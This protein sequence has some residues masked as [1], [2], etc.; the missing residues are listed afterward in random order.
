ML[1][2]LLIYPHSPSGAACPQDRAYI[3][4]KPL[5]AVLQPIMYVCMYV[6]I[7]CMYV[8]MCV[9]MCDYKWLL[10][11]TEGDHLHTTGQCA[12]KM[13]ICMCVCMYACT[14]VCINVHM[15]VCMQ[16]GM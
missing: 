11:P 4:V 10:P 7:L 13:C 5:T 6:C 9:C 12:D 16:V 8:C 3:S 15:Y 14:Y 2:V 1:G